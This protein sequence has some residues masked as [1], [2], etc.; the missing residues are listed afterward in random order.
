MYVASAFACTLSFEEDGRGGSSARKG[1]LSVGQPVPEVKSERGAVSYG[2]G[3]WYEGKDYHE[4]TTIALPPEVNE[5]YAKRDVRSEEL[6]SST[7]IL[8]SETSKISEKTLGECIPTYYFYLPLPDETLNHAYL[9]I[10]ETVAY[11]HSL[12][13]L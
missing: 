1:S 7:I 2:S 12:N 6:H 4:L 10:S 3:P 9:N 13:M 5:T 8:L 11:Y